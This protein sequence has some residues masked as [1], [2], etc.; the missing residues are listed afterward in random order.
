MHL[1]KEGKIDMFHRYWKPGHESTDYE[2]YYSSS[3]ADVYKVRKYHHSYEPYVIFKKVGTPWYVG[4]S[5]SIFSAELLDRCDQR[6]IGYGG[7][8]AACLFEMH[9]SGVSF[10]VLSDHFIIHQSHTYA[11]EAR[12]YEVSRADIS[13]VHKILITPQ[14]RFNN[15]VYTDFRE[16]TCLRYITKRLYENSTRPRNNAQEACRRSVAASEVHAVKSHA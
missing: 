7:N 4:C 12:K 9:I 11:E 10:Y 6:F 8:K 13:L 1:A 2:R 5:L 3:P 16:E 14:R 15:K